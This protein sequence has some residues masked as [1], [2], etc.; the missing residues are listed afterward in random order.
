MRKG[1][2]KKA[3]IL[4]SLF[5]LFFLSTVSLA[6]KD[7][8][9][10]RLKENI[11]EKEE[12]LDDLKKEKSK[13][14]KDRT[15]VQAII[16]SLKGKKQELAAIVTELDAQVEEVQGRID[17]LKE[18][19]VVKEQEIQTT[20]EEL[21]AAEQTATEQ[22]E[23]MKRRICFMYERGDHMYM[24]MLFTATSFADMLN[25]ADYIQQLSD[26]DK[27]K[28]EEYRLIVEDVKLTK[29][30][31]EEEKQVLGET[32]TAA[33]EEEENLNALID[34]KE[35][36]IVAYDAEIA[37]D[38]KAIKEYDAE[39]AD[40]NR[41]IAAVEAQIAADRAALAEADR[42][43]Y[44]GGKFA[45]PAPQYT[46]VS[47]EY[48]MRMHPTLHVEKLHNGIDLAAPGG[49]PIVAAYDGK[50]V[51][52]GYSS[53]MGN[54]CMIDHGDNLYTIY[55]HASAISVS[56]GTR[57]TKGQRIGSV[58]STGRSTGNHLHFGVRLNG[59]YVNPR[60]YINV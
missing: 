42:Q 8:D 24:E 39:I 27:R 46:R 4:L 3:G 23:A 5:L 59:N 41:L 26:Y 12:E 55:M 51:A 54:Y 30:I 49:S 18:M 9:T 50:V 52:T 37:Q 57:V 2:F 56:Q 38:E 7:K 40:Q 13:L 32:K 48:G 10:D 43:H 45:V 20:T 19:I 34:E 15:N 33:E 11:T 1:H 14:Q 22:Y 25:K 44:N 16:N 36:Q 6:D 58:G 53:S 31:L 47:D 35:K 17:E 28:L 29:A 60:N 21:A